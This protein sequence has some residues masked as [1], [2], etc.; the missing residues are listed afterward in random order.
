M[1]QLRHHAPADARV[2]VGPN[3][4]WSVAGTT[5]V[6]GRAFRGNVLWQAAELASLLDTATPD[7]I[8]AL[9][10]ELNGSFAAIK[11]DADG[12]HAIVD[13]IRG[14]PL[15]WV[16]ERH[17]RVV[18]DDPLC[19]VP[20][21]RTAGSDWTRQ[22]ELLETACVTGSDTL[23][24]DVHQVEAGSIVHVPLNRAQPARRT[25]WYQFRSGLEPVPPGDL[26]EQARAAH[27]AA[28][29][30]LVRVAGN[31]LI[32]VPLSA[33]LDSGI[34]ATLLAGTGVDRDQVLT[35]SFGR[36]GNHE[37]AG[38]RRVAETLGLRWEFA[39]YFDHTWRQLTRASWWSDHLLRGS[40]LAGVPGFDD[41]P[42]IGALRERG[43][44]PDGAVIVPGHTLD[45]LSGSQ[46]PGRL[47]RP[48]RPS[49]PDVLRALV[50]NYYKYRSDRTVAQILRRSPADV[51]AAISERADRSLSA[52]STP[53][54][55]S[56]AVALV[57]EWG[58]KERQAKMI[59]NSV[60][61]YET[62]GFRWWLP[63]WDREVMDFWSHVPLRQRVG[64]RLRR[65]I[66][67][68]VGW[69]LAARTR[70]ARVEAELERQARILTLDQPAKKVRNLARRSTKSNR[71]QNEEL[72]CLAL[73]GEARY[74]AS[75]HGTETPRAMLAE[76]VLAVISQ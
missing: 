54:D 27:Q 22:A 28:I 66:A 55:R 32:A 21:V 53:L 64:Q 57:D 71:Y 10:R 63:W 58:W 25:R 30:R 67:E 34:L 33:G 61:A 16:D 59:V 14:I 31:S 72:A 20:G 68:L 13:Q 35:F 17:T 42:A 40:S 60:R 47:L 26:L 49:R 37:S 3:R 44:L 11:E 8:P 29:E 18:T 52:T 24:D 2:V 43:L 76:D 1:T 6:T 48:R 65:E 19:A 45:F 12:V 56:A 23:L 51:A 4:T 9:L 46:I 39:P 73:F 5:R 38:S 74:R 69:P 70:L 7:G 41:V 75:F 36:P 50:A 62:H 15:Y